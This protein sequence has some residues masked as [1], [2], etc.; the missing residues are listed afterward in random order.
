[1]NAQRATK[2]FAPR[3][4]YFFMEQVKNSPLLPRDVMTMMLY[5]RLY[6]FDLTDGRTFWPM[7]ALFDISD[8]LDVISNI[9]G[10]QL[11]RGD[12]FWTSTP[13]PGPGPASK[14]TIAYDLVIT[15]YQEYA[16][17]TNLQPFNEFM[18][19]LQGVTASANRRRQ[20]QLSTDN[21]TTFYNSSGNYQHVNSNGDVTNTASVTMHQATGTAAKTCCA[22]ISCNNSPISKPIQVMNENIGM[23]QFLASTDPI[24]AIR[25]GLSGPGGMTGGRILIMGR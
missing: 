22:R 21:G 14:W 5:N 17:F 9:P 25:V 1:M 24:N 12:K 19:Y 11:V 10:H 2:Y 6:A 7:P 23:H 16:D 8:A 3:M 20:F 13:G 18:I 4:Y 15:S